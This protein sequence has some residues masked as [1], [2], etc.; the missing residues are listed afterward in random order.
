[1]PSRKHISLLVG[2]YL[3][4]GMRVAS[5]ELSHAHQDYDPASDWWLLETNNQLGMKKEWT[6]NSTKLE[7]LEELEVELKSIDR[8][9]DQV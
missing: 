5:D 9:K 3:P 4:L 1:V 8:D 2:G 7:S 6:R